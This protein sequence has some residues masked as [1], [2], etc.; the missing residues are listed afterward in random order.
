[1]DTPRHS[2]RDVSWF[3]SRRRLPYKRRSH[4]LSRAENSFYRAL[5]QALAAQYMIVPK[6]R[7][8]DVI[9]CDD[10]A[11]RAGHGDLL[12]RKHIDFVVCAYG[13]T[14]ILACIELDDSSHD[15]PVRQRRDEFLQRATDAAGLP[16]I[17]FRVAEHYDVQMID[18][19]VSG[20]LA[21]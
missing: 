13:S 9:H 21:D 12:G 8:A 18:E 3:L 6:V 20:T 17:R 15:S 2:R 19:A 14:R 10:T 5:K 4:L 7:L 1:M 11:W 16:L